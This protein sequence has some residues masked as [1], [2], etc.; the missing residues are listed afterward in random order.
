MFMKM[1]G[2]KGQYMA[3]C[4]QKFAF[5]CLPYTVLANCYVQAKYEL[6]LAYMRFITPC[7][8]LI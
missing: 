1:A 8:V 3:V 5:K 7:L 6:I 4:V 2:R